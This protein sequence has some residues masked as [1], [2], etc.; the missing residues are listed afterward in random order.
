MDE[1]NASHEGRP[2]AMAFDIDGCLIS[3]GGAGARA[4][5]FAFDSLFG[6]PADIGQF[7]EAGMTDPEV[8]SR[9]FESVIG[10]KPTDREMAKLMVAYLHQL[11]TEV[12]TSDGYRVMPG[13]EEL[14][15]GLVDLGILLGLTSGALEA[16][17]HI[18]LARA[19]L[20][21]FFCFGGYGS[22]SRDRGELTRRAIQRAGQVQGHPIDPRHVMVI[23]DTP[24]DIKAAHAA[25]AVG[26][27]VATGKY[28][29][30]QLRQSGADQAL[31][32]LV[33]WQPQLSASATVA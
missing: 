27:G 12:A 29:V 11:S 3:T 17:A 25:T 10:R 15:P 16:G 7:S 6:I 21:R 20:N 19:N 26:V 24:L 2:L 28:S 31:P 14:L 23:G 18:K 1:E 8:G 30:E 33:G 4:W 9:T 22:D 5:R 32:N 13:V